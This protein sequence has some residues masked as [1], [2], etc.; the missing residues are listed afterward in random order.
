M[1]SLIVVSPWIIKTHVEHGVFVFM[2]ATSGMNLFIGNNPYA[3]GC[4]NNDGFEKY[5]KFLVAEKNIV[6][7]N[8]EF[9]QKDKL[10]GELALEYIKENPRGFIGKMAEQLATFWLLPNRY[11]WHLPLSLPD[12]MIDYTGGL[13][14]LS[15]IGFF[16][17]T[18]RWKQHVVVYLLFALMIS[19]TLVTFYEYRYRL[20]LIPF[21]IMFTAYALNWFYS[22]V[23]NRRYAQ[24]LPPIIAVSVILVMVHY[25]VIPPLGFPELHNDVGTLA[26]EQGY[27]D[28]A[29]REYND[30]VRLA[31]LDAEVHYSLAR[32][33]FALGRISDSESELNTVIALNPKYARAYNDLAGIYYAMNRTDEAEAKLLDAI[34]ADQGYSNAHYNLGMLYLDR[35]D[36]EKAINEFKTSRQLKP[37]DYE[38]YNK[39]GIACMK[40]G[41]YDDSLAAFNKSL[42]IKPDNNEAL[43]YMKKLGD[44]SVA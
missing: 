3:N 11:C 5:E 43:G 23:K 17:S 9:Y 10:A 35:G 38:A 28:V 26:Y 31:P 44:V 25:Q 2:T 18:R 39:E 41:R 7:N 6:K 8:L 12:I 30:A 40:L 13:W 15:I 32:L 24:I 4:Y 14:I 27:Y 19:V 34:K 1:A 33:Y 37:D 29:E 20:P 22:E 21:Q 42:S 36:Y 16:Y